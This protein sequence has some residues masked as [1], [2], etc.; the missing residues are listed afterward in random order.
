MDLIGKVLNVSMQPYH[1][2]TAR[3]VKV[4]PAHEYGKPERRI[5]GYTTIVV[6]AIRMFE[7]SRLFGST[8]EKQVPVGRIFEMT[9]HDCQLEGIERTGRADYVYGV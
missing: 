2:G 3:V 4:R 7:A 8:S 9:F 1:G 5:P 6:E